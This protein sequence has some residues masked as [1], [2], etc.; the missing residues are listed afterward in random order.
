MQGLR[1]RRS[2]SISLRGNYASRY[3]YHE[4]IPD[5]IYIL[6]APLHSI[7]DGIQDQD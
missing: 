1:L 5:I 2:G 6:T 3:S 7:R 4:K